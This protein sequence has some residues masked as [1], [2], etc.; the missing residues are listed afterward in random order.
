[1]C[2]S[3]RLHLHVQI[4]FCVCFCPFASSLSP[5]FVH[6]VMIY[7]QS[8]SPCKV[9]H[10]ILND[11]KVDL[12][13]S[14][15][16]TFTMLLC[17]SLTPYA[18]TPVSPPCSALLG[19]LLPSAPPLLYSTGFVAMMTQFLAEKMGMSGTQPPPLGVLDGLCGLLHAE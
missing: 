2:S 11:M 9:L 10:K 13:R 8:G 16:H 19:Y 4:C 7:P 5:A 6:R 14:L 18:P 12:H 17:T 3:L 1:M 15:L